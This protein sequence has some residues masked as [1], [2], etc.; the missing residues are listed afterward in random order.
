MPS[1]GRWRTAIPSLVTAV[2][3]LL[4][5]GIW[6]LWVRGD[7]AISL[8]LYGVV[9]LSDALDGVAARRLGAT[10]RFGAF[11]DVTSDIA[12]VV[13]LLVFLGLSGAV[14]I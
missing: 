10:T 3:L 13:S 4:V 6:V 11:F 5:P 7:V 8:S 1:L 2:R 12:V 9:V 14:P